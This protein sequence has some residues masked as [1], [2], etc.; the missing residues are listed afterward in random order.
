MYPESAVTPIGRP[1]THQ[2]AYLASVAC[3]PQC[4]TSGRGW[5]G[6]GKSTTIGGTDPHGHTNP[7]ITRP[8]IG[9]P[10]SPVTLCESLSELP[11][12]P[13]AL[14][15]HLTTDRNLRWALDIEGVRHDATPP[16]T[17]RQA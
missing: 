1:G 11:T 5:Q 14:L 7:L 8:T 9:E 17:R 6:N 2:W 4:F 16:S 15:E 3:L 10:Y 13:H 12:E